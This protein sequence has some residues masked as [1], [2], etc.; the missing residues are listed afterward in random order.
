MEEYIEN[1]SYLIKNSPLSK[2]EKILVQLFIKVCI[3]NN[4]L[5]S[6]SNFINLTKNDAEYFLNN[7]YNFGGFGREN[8][9]DYQSLNKKGFLYPF[10]NKKYNYN[11]KNL[12]GSFLSIGNLLKVFLKIFILQNFF[13]KNSVIKF[14]FEAKKCEKLWLKRK[15][16][17]FV[18]LDDLKNLCAGNKF[19]YEIKSNLKDNFIKISIEEVINK[20][21]EESI[22]S[23]LIKNNLNFLKKEKSKK[24]INIVDFIIKNLIDKNIYNHDFII[25]I[26]NTSGLLAAANNVHKLINK[27][28]SIILNSQHGS[29]YYEFRGLDIL[30]AEESPAYSRKLIGFYRSEIIRPYYPVNGK[31]YSIKKNNFKDFILIVEGA[32]VFSRNINSP[33]LKKSKYTINLY[34][35]LIE[36]LSKNNIKCVLRRHPKSKIIWNSFNPNYLLE[37][38]ENIPSKYIPDPKD[39]KSFILVGLGH[40]LVYPLLN[41]RVNFFIIADPK[42]YNLSKE[43]KI[44]TNFLIKNKIL[45]EPSNLNEIQ[46]NYKN[47]FEFRKDINFS[48]LIDKNS[49]ILED[50]ISGL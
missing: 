31:K 6:T 41:S 50:W 47:C 44:F 23:Y 43:G 9:I 40:S 2:S 25:F 4:F 48:Q 15:N 39:F 45:I 12:I 28:K 38:F 1:L 37:N 11:L 32:D 13:K 30:L 35:N 16:L 19:K 20:G 42:D 29:A 36:G 24:I 10:I 21:V 18:P 33:N 22:I 27:K 46:K 26:D 34:Q 5:N 17:I 8:V 49:I 14:V 3:Y 7:T